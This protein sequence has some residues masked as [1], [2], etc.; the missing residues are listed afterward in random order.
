[1]ISKLKPSRIK[2]SWSADDVNRVAQA[3]YLFYENPCQDQVERVIKKAK[4]LKGVGVY[5]S[6]HLLRSVCILADM[7]HPNR[8]FIV[9]GEGASRKKYDRLCEMGMKNIDEVCEKLR[10]NGYVEA[11]SKL[12]SG[13]L[14]YCLCMGFRTVD[15]F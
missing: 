4:S 3:L 7:K 2:E 12:D 5:G 6:Q 1:M 9:M 15:G 14:A 10:T 11:A 8:E 13:I